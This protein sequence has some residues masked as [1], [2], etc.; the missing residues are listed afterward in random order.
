MDPIA[1]KSISFFTCFSKC[2]RKGINFLDKKTSCG[3]FSYTQI[4]LMPLVRMVEV[5]INRL[6]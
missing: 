2:G 4:R 5:R 3:I 1:P 6:S